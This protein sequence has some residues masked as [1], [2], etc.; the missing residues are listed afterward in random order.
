MDKLGMLVRLVTLAAAEEALKVAVVQNGGSMVLRPEHR[1]A[2][3]DLKLVGRRNDDDTYTLTAETP[4][5]GERPVFYPEVE[6][7]EPDPEPTEEAA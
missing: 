4:A 6:A 7:V 5:E 1:D 3:A 2:A